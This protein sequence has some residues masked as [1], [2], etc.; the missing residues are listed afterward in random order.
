MTFSC[1]DGKPVRRTVGVC[2]HRRERAHP[3]RQEWVASLGRRVA[4]V[5]HE[6]N[7]PLGVALTAT[8]LAV[9]TN[10]RRR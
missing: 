6:V 4:G 8:S 7:T 3:V 9:E 5:A 10:R 2:T 1:H